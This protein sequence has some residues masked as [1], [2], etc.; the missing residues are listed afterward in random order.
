LAIALGLAFVFFSCLYLVRHGF[1][2]WF[3]VGEVGGLVLLWFAVGLID[4]REAWG[5]GALGR[6]STAALVLALV[7][8][9]A[10]LTLTTGW[11][12]VRFGSDYELMSIPARLGMAFALFAVAAF[13]AWLGARLRRRGA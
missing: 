6:R 10:V 4:V 7:G 1:D 13:S 5:T 11:F 3:V 2:W 12:P 8:P 9:M